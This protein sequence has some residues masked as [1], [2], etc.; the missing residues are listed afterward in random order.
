M[1]TN[2]VP[3]QVTASPIPDCVENEDLAP[4]FLFA[5]VEAAQQSMMALGHCPPHANILGRNV[6]GTTMRAHYVMPLTDLLEATEGD[7]TILSVAIPKVSREFQARYVALAVEAYC[8]SGRAED[9]AANAYQREHGTLKG[10]PGAREV[11][12]VHMEGREG[13]AFLVFPVLRN[14]SGKVT[15]FGPD[16]SGEG[17]VRLM[18]GLGFRLLHHEGDLPNPGDPGLTVID[19]SDFNRKPEPGDLPN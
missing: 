5:V 9:P 1:A 19:P 13:I 16:E 14:D 4:K 17:D 7:P 18:A 15:G 8:T 10:F 2:D 3:I 6:Q 12:S 11:L